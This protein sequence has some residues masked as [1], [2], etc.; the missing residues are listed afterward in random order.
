MF[1]RFMAPHLKCLCELGY[2][3]GL[4]TQMHSCGGVYELI[5]SIINLVLIACYA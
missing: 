2:S 4:K 3:Y 1:D 5:P